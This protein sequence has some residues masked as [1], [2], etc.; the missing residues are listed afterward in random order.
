MTDHDDPPPIPHIQASPDWLAASA[1]PALDPALP[2][3]DA[4]HHFSEH[5][6][7]YGLPDL[8][9]DIGGSGHSVDTT[10]YIQCGWRYR[11]A[12]PESMRSLGEIEAVMAL[13]RQ[14]DAT[15]GAPRVAAGIVGHAELL[16]GDGVEPVLSALA[17][18]AEGRLRGIRNSGARHP[19]FRH[20]VLARP[21]PG[22]YADPGF[23]R[24][25]ARLRHHDLSFDAWVYH[26]QLD[27]VVA[28]ARAFPDTLLVLDHVGGVLGVGP[29]RDRRETAIAEWCPALRRLAACENVVVKL[30]GFGTGVFGFDF[31]AQARP[32]NSEQLAR[33]WRPLIEPTLDAFGAH[34]CFF[35]SNFPVDRGSAGYGVVWNAFKRLTAQASA[36]ER[37]LLFHGTATR[38][39]RLAD[40]GRNP[41]AQG[42]VP[43]N[44]R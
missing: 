29:Y 21:M 1:E 30:G 31:A 38:V 22:L 32:P 2:I 24:G 20:G 8:L 15:P 39:Y 10:V 17:Q 4:H 3:V 25:Y 7:G 13:A 16:L 34:R 12:G 35:E 43:K 40:P 26:P 44:G 11:T 27:E 33:A 19:A 28:L 36:D 42:T 41:T 9:H 5:W 18:A 37:A 14:A 23:R 6:G